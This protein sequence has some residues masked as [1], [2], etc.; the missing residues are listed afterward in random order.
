[1]YVD[2]IRS[3]QST[4]YAHIRRPSMTIIGK[5]ETQRYQ[6]RSMITAVFTYI[7]I[8]P[9][10]R[11]GSVSARTHYVY[12]RSE[13]PHF[14]FSHEPF[15]P[16]ARRHVRTT[17]RFDS[18]ELQSCSG[19]NICV[20]HGSRVDFIDGSSGTTATAAGWTVS[21][22]KRVRPYYCLLGLIT[23]ASEIIL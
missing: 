2:C 13:S 1:M 4:R 6:Q 10:C 17:T 5:I 15:V 3:I 21:Y 16:S 11:Y 12:C 23:R 20:G 7:S 8:Q 19:Y 9:L 22:S 18:F 14:S